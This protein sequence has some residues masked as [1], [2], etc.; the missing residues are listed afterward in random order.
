MQNLLNIIIH[1]YY[2]LFI[3][4]LV[5]MSLSIFIS[6]KVAG[7]PLNNDLHYI[8]WMFSVA[9]S[10]TLIMYVA[11]IVLLYFDE[12][13]YSF[14][15]ATFYMVSVIIFTI[16]LNINKFE[17]AGFMVGSILS[18]LFAYVLMRLFLQKMRN[19]IFMMK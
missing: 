3:V 6:F 15:I 13:K 5:V 9:M 18:A 8:F 16:V 17:G 19:L 14:F 10:M 12:R 4:Q 7:G 2:K 1:F 11:K